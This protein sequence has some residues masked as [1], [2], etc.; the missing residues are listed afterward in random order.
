MAPI[1]DRMTTFLEPRDYA[2]YV[3]P[4]ERPPLH[5][6]RILPSEEMHATIVEK[7][8][9]TNQQVSPFGSH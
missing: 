4:S 6:Q 1:H 2:E 8:N 5:L 9:I 7:S 3:A